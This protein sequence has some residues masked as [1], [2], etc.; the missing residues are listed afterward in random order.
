MSRP[1]RAARGHLPPHLE[2]RISF[3]GAPMPDMIRASGEEVE[4]G[5]PMW[6]TSQYCENCAKF[7]QQRVY[8]CAN[9][10]MCLC[11]APKGMSDDDCK[12]P[13]PFLTTLTV[14]LGTGT[15]PDD[16]ERN[17]EVVRRIRNNTFEQLRKHDDAWHKF[18]LYSAAGNLERAA[19][20]RRE[21]KR[22]LKK[23]PVSRANFSK[24]CSTWCEDF[25]FG[26]PTTV[27]ETG[28]P[29]TTYIWAIEV[30]SGQHDDRWHVHLHVLTPTRQDAERINAAWQMHREQRDV[31]NTDISGGNRE[32]YR[33]RPGET[34]TELAKS[35]PVA[36]I[37]AYVSKAG[38]DK[39]PP[40][41]RQTYIEGMQDVRKY[42]AGGLW[43]PLGIGRDP[44]D[45]PVVW[46]V[47]GMGRAID[48]AD[49]LA[50]R[51]SEYSIAGLFHAVRDIEG[52]RDVEQRYGYARE[53][54][55]RLSRV[56]EDAY[57]AERDTV[58][59]FLAQYR[60]FLELGRCEC[61]EGHEPPGNRAIPCA[62]PPAE[63]P[64]APPP[65][66]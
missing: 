22:R 24:Y 34:P 9:R 31:A 47:D 66:N 10:A 2:R 20:W 46:I 18:R 1:V 49:Y 3:C 44:S 4:A 6:C 41:M 56:P 11:G 32:S 35:D 57:R 48:P 50:G 23:P 43:R 63:P 38:L 17:L 14:R 30:T 53:L 55:K 62:H 65:C 27:D 36:Y 29:K 5:A 61:S 52:V 42:D 40:S 7:Y 19:H 21:L 26:P 8:A 64:R 45:D 59:T 28:K 37:V 58:A 15:G 16:L 13:R 54:A 51:A 39:L 25:G 33:V 12:C 60:T